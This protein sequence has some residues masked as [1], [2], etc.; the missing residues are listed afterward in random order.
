ME[1]DTEDDHSFMEDDE[2][3]FIDPSE[4]IEEIDYDLRPPSDDENLTADEKDGDELHADGSRATFE[5][6]SS[7]VYTVEID[8]SNPRNVLTGGGDDRGFLID[9][10]KDLQIASHHELSGHTDSVCSVGFS[11][12]G[13]LFS[14]ASFDGRIFVWDSQLKT[15][16]FC[17]EGPDE[18]EWIDWHSQGPIILA[19][20]RDGT[21][22]MWLAS[23]GEC[24]QVF[25]GHEG[26]V[27]CGKFTSNG[28]LIVTGGED[29]SVRVWSPKNG[30]C[31]HIFK[32][33]GFHEGSLTCLAVHPD[34]EQSAVVLSGS[35]DGTARLLHLQNKK[36]LATF[37]HSAEVGSESGEDMEGEKSFS[38]EGVGF[39]R[40]RKWCFTGGM[41]GYAKVWDIVNGNCRISC[42]HPMGVT[43]VI[44][45]P[46]EDVIYS[47]C[48]DGKC[49]E[50]DILQ[51]S[52]LRTFDG[53]K[54]IV[55]DF[56]VSFEADYL[57]T[58]SEDKTAKIFLLKASEEES[59]SM[60]I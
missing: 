43:K 51:G 15:Q 2:L 27:T 42:K 56:D 21:V 20:G 46:S 7:V 6:H 50:W 60:D 13:Q 54:E 38:V 8:R 5:G 31:R 18:I 37:V 23:T 22:W 39:F 9:L 55:N 44:A 36:V 26:T 41:D 11:H 4:V 1:K 17:L 48:V 33:F 52:C 25:T 32:G 24:M 53:H 40:R 58:A 16:K 47:S 19:G 45:H 29:Q 30:T 59:D 49:R 14:T 57:V 12:D 10:S 3:S 35:E 28:R 34:P